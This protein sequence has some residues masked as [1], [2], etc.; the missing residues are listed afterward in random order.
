MHRPKEPTTTNVSDLIGAIYK[1][2]L[3][4]PLWHEDSDKVHR[5]RAGYAILTKMCH[6]DHLTEDEYNF[7]IDIFTTC[8]ES[9]AQ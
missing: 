5:V 7:I 8:N 2:T 1:F 3:E 6:P 9:Q 4:N